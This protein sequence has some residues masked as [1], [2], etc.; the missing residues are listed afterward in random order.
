MQLPDITPGPPVEEKS[1]YEVWGIKIKA[2]W[3]VIPC[4]LVERYRIWKESAPSIFRA[5]EWTTAMQVKAADSTRMLVL[6][7]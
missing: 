6:F 2:Y 4:P 1:H 5:E 7:Y 3:H